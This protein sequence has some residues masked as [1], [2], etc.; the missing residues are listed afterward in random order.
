M[1]TK[2]KDGLFLGDAETSQDIDFLVSN[3][4]THVINCCGTRVPN[5]WE[6]IGLQYLTLRW[7][8]SAT[9]DGSE[10]AVHRL[11]TF[12][13]D[14]LKNCDTILVHSMDGSS[15]ACAVV[16]SF[17]MTKYFW[18]L[19]QTMGFLRSKRV[20]LN[21]LPPVVEQLRA[22]EQRL[23]KLASGDE[24]LSQRLRTQFRVGVPWKLLPKQ[25]RS[26]T[27]EDEEV[28]VNTFLNA[29]ASNQGPRG[30]GP[31]IASAMAPQVHSSSVHKGGRR[32]RRATRLSWI[33]DG[34]DGGV[35][36]GRQGMTPGRRRGGN[37][38]AS[39]G[40]ERPP[41]SSYTSMTLGPG[42]NDTFSQMSG[43][44]SQMSNPYSRYG[45]AGRKPR[46]GVNSPAGRSR[47]GAGHSP[48]LVGGKLVSILKGS[49]KFR[50]QKELSAETSEVSVSDETENDASSEGQAESLRDTAGAR[51]S[52]GKEKVKVKEKGKGKGAARGSVGGID[53]GHNDVN[54]PIV[55]WRTASDVGSGAGQGIA[56][57][58]VAAAAAAGSGWRSPPDSVEEE[59]RQSYIMDRSPS[60]SQRPVTMRRRTSKLKCI[61]YVC[62]GLCDKDIA[63]VKKNCAASC[64][65]CQS[66]SSIAKVPPN[67][68]VKEG[69]YTIRAAA[70]KIHTE[71]TLPPSI[72]ENCPITKAQVSL[73]GF[74]AEKQPSVAVIKKGETSATFDSGAVGYQFEVRLRLGNFFGW[75]K[76]TRHE[77]VTAVNA[78]QKS[79]GA[80]A[81]AGA[82]ACKDIE[83]EGSKYSC[84]DFARLKLCKLN[85]V[86]KSCRRSC[87]L[88]TAVDAKEEK[89]EEKP[90]TMA[91]SQ[92]STPA[93][94]EKPTRHSPSSPKPKSKPTPSPTPSPKAKPQPRTAGA[95]SPTTN[96]EVSILEPAP[97]KKQ[98]QHSLLG[99]E[100]LSQRGAG[101]GELYPLDNE[102]ASTLRILEADT[103]P[104]IFLSGAKG[105]K[106]S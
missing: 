7:S 14:A 30:S 57:V 36:G 86:K 24:E 19:D 62:L 27:T 26:L 105:G 48:A 68:P 72:P 51:R 47:T 60:K 104:V 9:F 106:H 54:S 66:Q 79:A 16:A 55:Q 29:L 98:A 15:R 73:T 6:R 61:D 77:K 23:I 11:N 96:G 94:S 59:M 103:T 40:A 38:G 33:D 89:E 5:S 85:H 13:D 58:G 67:F 65:L 37:G 70:G 41:G 39:M 21:P 31:I 80:G 69:K 43:H 28:L 4:I 20:D 90:K 93:T 78:R 64:G 100:E 75:S 8:N 82:G 101:N 92:A 2:I 71:W 49:E 12:I 91:T 102:P 53:L 50:A 88:C 46:R 35:G 34:G 74:D 42:W 81:D 63:F 95:R 32:K 99:T 25:H 1:A 76:W 17:M 10:A 87:G 45:V 52:M 18:N 56:S 3:K 83:K 22:I 44:G 84:A 97:P